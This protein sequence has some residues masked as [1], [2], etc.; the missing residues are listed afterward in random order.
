VQNDTKAAATFDVSCNW[1]CPAGN[2]RTWA[3]SIEQGAYLDAGK[4]RG[5]ERD[6]NMGCQPL[7]SVLVITC[8]LT[9]KAPN[10][11]TKPETLDKNSKQVTIPSL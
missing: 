2:T 5:F 8:E 3:V 9:K 7:P 6:V 11:Q 1:A 10:S 4:D